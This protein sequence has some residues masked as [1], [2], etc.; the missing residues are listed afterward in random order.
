MA[1]MPAANADH[2][3][4]PTTVAMVGLSSY[5]NSQGAH[6]RKRNQSLFEHRHSPLKMP[7]RIARFANRFLPDAAKLTM[8]SPG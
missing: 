7:A 2:N 5:A 6:R 8:I 4:G 3:I 1:M